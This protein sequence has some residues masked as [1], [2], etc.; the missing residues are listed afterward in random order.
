MPGINLYFLRKHKYQILAF[1]VLV[2]ASG[3]CAL[4]GLLLNWYTGMP[5]LFLIWNL[6]LAWIPLILAVSMYYID[7]FL[8]HQR[9]RKILWQ[10]FL[11]F[12]WLIFY[13]NATYIVTDLIHLK[14]RAGGLFWYDLIMFLSVAWLG[15]VLGFISLYLLQEIVTRAYGRSASWFF[16]AIVSGLSSF[17]IYLGRF[18]RWNSWDIIMN[19]ADLTSNILNLLLNPHPYPRPL[20][21]SLFFFTFSI[22]GYLIF[23]AFAHLHQE[24]QK[25]I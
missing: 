15:L 20:A 12:G 5:Y 6:F 9:L 11:G 4:M 7:K 8:S 3:A 22:F 21:F 1:T 2:F 17:G 25:E 13:P 18:L 10:V 19:P 16:V 14:A 23:F 24:L